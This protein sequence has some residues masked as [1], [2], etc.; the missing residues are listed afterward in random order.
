M[1]SK[2]ILSISR[3]FLSLS[4]HLIENRIPPQG[5]S[6]LRITDTTCFDMLIETSNFKM[7][8]DE[9]DIASLNGK[10]H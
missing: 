6:I 8:L 1:S 9:S 2:Q 5:Q 4:S 3:K 10:C 7:C